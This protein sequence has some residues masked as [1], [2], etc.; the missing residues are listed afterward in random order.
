MH[1]L[2]NMTRDNQ[3]NAVWLYA[4]T[5]N[6]RKIVFQEIKCD[7]ITSLHGIH[8]KTTTTIKTG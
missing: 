1:I 3:F 8:E 6:T 4:F 2:P 5:A 7:G